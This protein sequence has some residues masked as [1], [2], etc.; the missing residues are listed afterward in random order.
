[1]SEPKKF[2]RPR[3]GRMLAGVCAAFADYF[4]IDATLVRI[5]Y[6]LIFL[7]LSVPTFIFGASIFGGILYFILMLLIP[8]KKSKFNINNK[9]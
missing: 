4:N 7:L 9:Q 8:E 6:V 2:E 5:I 1:M 3:T